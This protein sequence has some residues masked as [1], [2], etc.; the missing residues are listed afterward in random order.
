LIV[1][2]QYRVLIVSCASHG[3]S[4]ARQATSVASGSAVPRGA[5]RVDVV[6]WVLGADVMS[7]L[8]SPNGRIRPV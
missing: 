4:Q 8:P 3:C 2:V 5:V 1:A 6:V 7:V